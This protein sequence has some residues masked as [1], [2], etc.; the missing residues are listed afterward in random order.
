MVLNTCI[1]TH[2]SVRYLRFVYFIQNSQSLEH[3][4][5]DTH[6]PPR[7]PQIGIEV[8][9]PSTTYLGYQIKDLVNNNSTGNYF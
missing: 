2:I 7:S 4:P 3:S 1:R 9:R 8:H 6:S 5:L